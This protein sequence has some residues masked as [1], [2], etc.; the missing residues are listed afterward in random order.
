MGSLN[1]RNGKLLFD[2]RYLGV[3]CREQLK[4]SDSAANRK[5]AKAI[6]ER[7]EAEITLG[8]FVYNDYFPQSKRVAQFEAQLTR[9]NQVQSDVPS[10]KDF[11]ETW[12]GEC[13]V[14]W[15]NSHKKNVR[16]SLDRYL[17]PEFGEMVMD[18]ITKASILAFRS[19]ISKLPGRGT[20]TTWSA[21]LNTLTTPS[22]RFG[23]Y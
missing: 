5:R 22:L 23:R 7:I 3:R 14:E 10:F 2:F 15:K 21:Q 18:Q 1:T 13:E 8:T 17:I 12:F 19:K 4:L 20:N 11:S 9:I 6:L 16:G